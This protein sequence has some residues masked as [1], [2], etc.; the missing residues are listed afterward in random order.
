MSEWLKEHASKAKQRPTPA[1]LKRIKAC[2]IS[3]LTRQTD[4]SVC[5]RK[6]R[7]S[8]RCRALRITV[9]SQFVFSLSAIHEF[10]NV[11]IYVERQPRP[12]LAPATV[13]EG[14]YNSAQWAA[15]KRK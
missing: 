5:V 3:D 1:T 14:P 8:S 2:A 10:K 4:H 7:C 15:Q 9:L 11:H 13:Q 6:P 12:R